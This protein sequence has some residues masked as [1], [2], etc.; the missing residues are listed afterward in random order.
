MRIA[1]L[2]R[3]IL[4]AF[5]ALSSVPPADGNWRGWGGPQRDF[6]SAATGLFPRTGEKWLATPPKKIW[7]R[8]LGDGYSAIAVEGGVLYT[9]YRR[10]G[11]DVIVALDANTGRQLWEYSY[12]APFKNADAAG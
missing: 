11:N 6:T 8:P 3:A 12:A 7:Q 4:F 1:V 9:G 10:E 2:A 5:G